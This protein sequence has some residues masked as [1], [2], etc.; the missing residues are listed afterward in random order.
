M[1]LILKLRMNVK[2]MAATNSKLDRGIFSNFN[3]YKNAICKRSAKNK[4]FPKAD[5]LD[6]IFKSREK[7][8]KCQLCKKLNPFLD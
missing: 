7:I 5:T 6:S 4:N 3:P 8:R 2:R 1:A